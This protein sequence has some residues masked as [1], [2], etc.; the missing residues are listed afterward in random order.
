M[1]DPYLDMVFRAPVMAISLHGRMI[2]WD[3]MGN[4]RIRAAGPREL[5]SS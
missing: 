2:P 3:S 4:Y 1:Q 5:A